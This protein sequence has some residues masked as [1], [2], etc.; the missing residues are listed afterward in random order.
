MDR[1]ECTAALGDDPQAALELV[2]SRLCQVADDGS[3]QPDVPAGLTGSPGPSCTPNSV[4]VDEHVPLIGLDCK[5]VVFLPMAR[6]VL[7]IVIEELRAANAPL[8][9]GCIFTPGSGAD[10]RGTC[11]DPR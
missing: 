2:T 6:A 1:D 4:T 10:L 3:V 5:G 9:G 11:R 8:R 7:E